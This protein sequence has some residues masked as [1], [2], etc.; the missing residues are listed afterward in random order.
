MRAILFV[1]WQMA[2]SLLKKSFGKKRTQKVVH[3]TSSAFFSV[4]WLFHS[5]KAL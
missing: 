1:C 2:S 4:A 5:S 3:T